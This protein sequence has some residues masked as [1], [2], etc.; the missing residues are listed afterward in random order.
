MQSPDASKA[1]RAVLT[2]GRPWRGCVV[3]DIEWVPNNLG[4]GEFATQLLFGKSTIGIRDKVATQGLEHHRAKTLSHSV[5]EPPAMMVRLTDC[6]KRDVSVEA[7]LDKIGG[8][9]GRAGR[10]HNQ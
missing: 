2:Q 9:K 1:Q 10:M 6:D 5:G 8:G 4:I 7:K 3:I